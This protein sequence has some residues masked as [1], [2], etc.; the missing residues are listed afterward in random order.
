LASIEPLLDTEP[1]RALEALLAVYRATFE[2]RVAT[3][4][5]RLGASL[6]GAIDGLP[7]KQREQ[8]EVLCRLAES[9]PPAQRSGLLEAFALFAGSAQGQSVWPAVEALASLEAD[10]RIARLGLRLLLAPRSVHGMTAKLFRRLVNC[11]ER[12]GHAG[13]APPLRA[14]SPVLFYDARR[15]ANVAVRL[16]KRAPPAL[17]EAALSG[18]EARVVSPLPPSPPD[19]AGVSE[20]TMLEAILAAPDDDAPRLM[21]ADWLIGRQRP[22]GE[23]ISLQIARSNGRVSAQARHREA[24]LLQRHRAA[25]LGPFDRRVTL[26]DSRFERGVLVRCSLRTE[27]PRHP[28][29]RLLQDVEFNQARI[30]Q[31]LRFDSLRTARNL[32]IELLP[33][34]MERA[35]RLERAMTHLYLRG[36]GALAWTMTRA[37]LERLP[38]PLTQLGFDAST[39]GAALTCEPLAF[40]L[41]EAF[42]LPALARLER[43]W[44]GY[45]GPLVLPR[46]SLAALPA[47]M[48]VL[49]LELHNP[50]VTVE[51][52]RTGAGWTDAVV[53]GMV[54]DEEA[55]RLW[56]LLEALGCTQLLVRG[57]RSS[58]R[59]DF[60][61]RAL[62]ARPS[63]NARL[64]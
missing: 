55:G 36:A 4:I 27:L 33:E 45:F 14:A 54:H 40:V 18:L 39:S 6:G 25:F 13:L 49:E 28:L 24:E 17:D 35:P 62:A 58:Y 7:L 29:V 23:F 11:V 34:L 43:L 26:S 61:E 31:G 1:A 5:E 32:S 53:S 51:L 2:P 44:L 57:A 8:G 50:W 30:P 48:Q 41:R 21:Y 56:A 60:L 16:E 38:R 47:T 15:V 10:P 52:T 9:L 64:A 42:A 59:R 12:H 63:L 22:L 46:Q 3:L 20:Q 37:L 19:E